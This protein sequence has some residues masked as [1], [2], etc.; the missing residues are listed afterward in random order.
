MN[1]ISVFFSFPAAISL[2]NAYSVLSGKSINKMHPFGNTF[3]RGKGLSQKEFEKSMKTCPRRLASS[4]RGS[5][6]LDILMDILEDPR[7]SLRQRD[8]IL[9]DILGE[10]S[11]CQSLSPTFRHLESDKLEETVLLNHIFC[12]SKVMKTLSPQILELMLDHISKNLE[13]FAVMSEMGLGRLTRSLHGRESNGIRALLNSK[14]L[15]TELFHKG[16]TI[17]IEGLSDREERT[18]DP[19]GGT[20]GALGHVKEAILNS[21]HITPEDIHALALGQYE[22]ARSVVLESPFITEADKVVV[23]LLNNAP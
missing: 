7:L 16:L 21:P 20:K 18:T 2:V 14:V 4:L 1:N 9:L 12:S 23:A 11:L 15:S 8:T 13:M 3:R 19:F 10:D 17:L 5:M 22:W 6:E